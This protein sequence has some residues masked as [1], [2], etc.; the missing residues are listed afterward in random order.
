MKTIIEKILDENNLTQVNLPIDNMFKDT[1][2]I[3]YPGINK[4]NN[5]KELKD[6]LLDNI[7]VF[8]KDLGKGF[9]LVGKEYELVIEN[10]IKKL[11][12]YSI[13][14]KFTLL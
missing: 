13:I 6:K 11:I 7:I 14:I 1:Y 9:V 2:I 5:E 12:Y 10:S 8:L 3:D 4:V